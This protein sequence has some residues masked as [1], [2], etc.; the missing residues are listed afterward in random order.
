MVFGKSWKHSF[1]LGAIVYDSI[2]IV[3]GPI[4]TDGLE[5]IGPNEVSIPQLY[6]KAVIDLREDRKEG[7]AF[8]LKNEASQ[9]AV[10]SFAISIDSLERVSG[11]ELYPFL[12]DALEAKIE[13][14]ICISCWDW[15]IHTVEARPASTTKSSTTQCLGKNKIGVIDVK[16]K[17]TKRV[18]IAMYI[19]HKFHRSPLAWRLRCAAR[20]QPKEANN[21]IVKPW[22]QVLDVRNT[23]RSIS[24]F[25]I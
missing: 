20:V 23:N 16:S 7:I 13:S 3:T 11:L 1:D 6:Y 4:L 17:P 9:D 22:M 12:D 15:S 8:L 2:Y 14:E 18:A 24:R 19:L 5:A 25:I 21:V 10:Q